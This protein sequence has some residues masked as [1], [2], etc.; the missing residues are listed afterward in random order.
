MDGQPPRND[1]WGAN[2]QTVGAFDQPLPPPPPQYAP[3]Q[4]VRFQ[5][6]GIVRASA[7]NLGKVSSVN[8]ISPDSD[9]V[10]CCIFI[11]VFVF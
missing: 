3:V 7:R 9:I 2:D 11:V 6:R 8:G 10:V 1:S 5:W 4:R